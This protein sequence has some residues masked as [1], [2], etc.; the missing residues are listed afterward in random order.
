MCGL[1]VVADYY[2]FKAIGGSDKKITG[3]YVDS[4]FRIKQLLSFDSVNVWIWAQ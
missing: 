1:F 3:E 4:K 2:F